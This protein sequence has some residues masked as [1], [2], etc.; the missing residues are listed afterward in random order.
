MGV[1]DVN[2]HIISLATTSTY[3]DLL[4]LAA[5]K[6]A[7]KFNCVNWVT[8]LSRL[9]R[10]T[11]KVEEIKGDPRVSLRQSLVHWTGG[12]GGNG[13]TWLSQ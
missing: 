9:G 7:E 5:G 8:V 13:F 3:K 4:A 1:V 11:E 6:D 10:M 2:K 12:T